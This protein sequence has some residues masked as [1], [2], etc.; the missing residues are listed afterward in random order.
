MIYE[1]ETLSEREKYRV[2]TSCIVPRPIAWITT[3]DENGLANAAPFS[4]FTGVSID[5]PLV[6]FAAER[7]QTKKKDTVRNIEATGQFVINLVTVANVDQMNETSKDYLPNEDELK[8]ANLS[9][10]PS[11]FVSPPSIKESPI[12]MECVLERIIEIGSSPHSLV[13]GEVKA[14]EVQDGLIQGNRIDMKQLE[15]VGRMGGKWYVKTD[16]LFELDRLDW[17]K[18]EV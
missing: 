3:A 15:A 8:K 7:R 18:E 9:A 17:R 14:V 5:P 6:I 12:R 13:I 16:H 1:M 11:K 4:F 2:M 10:V